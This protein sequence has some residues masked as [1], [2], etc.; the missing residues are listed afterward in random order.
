MMAKFSISLSTY[1][2][3]F[4]GVAKKLEVCAKKKGAES[5]G[6]WIKAISNHMYWIAMT[7]G[8]DETMKLAKWTSLM[9][10]IVDRHEGHSY[11]FPRCE[12]GLIEDR[13]W[14]KEGI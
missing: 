6:P 14:V 13:V 9:N 8:D 2:S 12:H 10:H 4:V 3:I 1:E 11:I 7:S 5:I